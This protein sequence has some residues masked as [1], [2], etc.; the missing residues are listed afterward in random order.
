MDFLDRV[1]IYSDES[2]KMKFD[3]IIYDLINLI[4]EEW[5]T[6]EEKKKFDISYQIYDTKYI[7]NDDILRL[8]LYISANI[9]KRLKKICR[10]R[11]INIGIGFKLAVIR[12]YEIRFHKSGDS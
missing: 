12:F 8:Q 7:E 6:E 2:T 11:N 1:R 3:S 10:R 9:W 4:I 5:I